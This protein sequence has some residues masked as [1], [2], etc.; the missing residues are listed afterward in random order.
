M[1]MISTQI[2]LRRLEQELDSAYAEEERAKNVKNGIAWKDKAE[3]RT[4]G[5]INC[6]EIIKRIKR[7]YE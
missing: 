6:I 3:G 7:D 1:S 5:I 2:I 4:N